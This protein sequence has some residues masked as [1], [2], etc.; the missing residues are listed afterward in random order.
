MEIVFDFQTFEVSVGE[1]FE[2]VRDEAIDYV[3]DESRPI[4]FICERIDLYVES[5]QLFE[6][7][8]VRTDLDF[9]RQEKDDDDESFSSGGGGSGG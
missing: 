5:N 8:N 3:N 4:S 6:H 2:A 7:A 1:A 9:R